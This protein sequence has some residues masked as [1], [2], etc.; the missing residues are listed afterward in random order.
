MK[1]HVSAKKMSRNGLILIKKKR[2]I[3]FDEDRSERLT[4]VKTPSI[5]KSVDDTI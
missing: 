3:F 2:I 4:G 1:K 5:I